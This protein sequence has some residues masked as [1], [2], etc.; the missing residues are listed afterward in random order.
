M[1][2]FELPLRIL[3]IC[4]RSARVS[5]SGGVDREAGVGEVTTR[6]TKKSAERPLTRHQIFKI[7]EESS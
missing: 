1:I 2:L 6:E 5:E 7:P 3:K 4:L